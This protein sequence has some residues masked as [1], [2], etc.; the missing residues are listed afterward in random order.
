[1]LSGRLAELR[2]LIRST[3]DVRLY[4]PSTGAEA[5]WQAAEDRLA[6]VR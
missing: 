4:L 2:A 1:V 6:G 5:A 3:Q